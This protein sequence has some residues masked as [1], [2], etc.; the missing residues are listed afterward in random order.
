MKGGHGFRGDWSRDGRSTV[1]R[2]LQRSACGLEERLES[3]RLNEDVEVS[4]VRGY[5][6]SVLSSG[7]KVEHTAGFDELGLTFAPSLQGTVEHD[8]RL[9]LSVV[10]VARAHAAKLSALLDKRESPAGC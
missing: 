7:R 5:A 9:R 4:N 8:E 1:E 3:G 2:L 6:E 10:K